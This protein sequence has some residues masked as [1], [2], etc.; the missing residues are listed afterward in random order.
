[1]GMAADALRQDTVLRAQTLFDSITRATYDYAEPASFSTRSTPAT[2]GIGRRFTRLVPTTS[3]NCALS[4]APVGLINLTR[5]C[6]PPTPQA[7]LDEVELADLAAVAICFMENTIDASGFPLEARHQEPDRQT[8]DRVG[9][10]PGRRADHGRPT[11]PLDGSIGRGRGMGPQISR[12][13]CLTSA[14]LAR[15]KG[16]FPLFDRDAYLLNETVSGLDEDLRALIATNGIRNALLTSVAADLLVA[17]NIST[18]EPLFALAH[19]RKVLQPDGS[20]V[21]KEV[22]GYAPRCFPSTRMI[23]AVFRRGVELAIVAEELKQVLDQR[24]GQWSKGRYVGSLVAAIGGIIERHMIETG[25]LA[26]AEP[27]G[28]KTVVQASDGVSAT[29]LDPCIPKAATRPVARSRVPELRPLWMV[30][31]WLT[32]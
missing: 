30:Q 14:H 2:S 26:P 19:T 7:F 15:E 17:D 16:A 18:R 31:V 25:F 27:A 13:A 9:D 23:S 11:L 24:G 22:S 4:R 5:R 32:D 28:A 1:M 12:A 6:A 29:R 21:E 20:R 10:R 3:S 8:S